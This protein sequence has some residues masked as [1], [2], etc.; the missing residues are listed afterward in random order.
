MNRQKIIKLARKAGFVIESLWMTYPTLALPDLLERFAA[1]VAAA[2]R[3]RCAKRCEA[4]LAPGIGR[5]MADA[6]RRME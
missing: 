3:E 5:E 6:I 1:L 2:E 4:Y